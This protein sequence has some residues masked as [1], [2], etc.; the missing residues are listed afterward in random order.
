[1]G[2]HT[3]PPGSCL[4]GPNEGLLTDVVIL[5]P[6]DG[7]TAGGSLTSGNKG[8]GMWAGLWSMEDLLGEVTCTCCLISSVGM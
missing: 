4:G 5:I 1:M 2:Q 8:L 3:F 7:G 6:R